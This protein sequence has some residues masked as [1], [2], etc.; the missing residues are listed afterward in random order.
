MLELLQVT[1]EPFI[2][3][4]WKEPL[5]FDLELTPNVQKK[6]IQPRT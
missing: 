3:I 5:M 2:C 4:K 1:Y 6:S